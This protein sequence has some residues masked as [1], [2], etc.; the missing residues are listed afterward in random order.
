MPEVCHVIDHDVFK[1]SRLAWGQTNPYRLKAVMRAWPIENFFRRAVDQ[2]CDLQIESPPERD[3][4][5]PRRICISADADPVLLS[6]AR[7]HEIV[8]QLSAY[9]PLMVI[10]GGVD[11]V[12]DDLARRPF[13]GRGPRGAPV[14][15]RD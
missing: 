8:L 4:L 5:F 13:I 7:E 10:R 12:A 11:E 9:Q 15:Q 3:Q 14:T 1:S 6:I 2:S